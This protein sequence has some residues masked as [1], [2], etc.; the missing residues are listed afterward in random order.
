MT[1]RSNM[2]GPP[3]A[4]PAGRSG[5]GAAAGVAGRGQRRWR[6]S[7]EARGSTT[8]ATGAAASV[9]PSESAAAGVGR[10]T[11]ADAVTTGASDVSAR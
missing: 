1:R 11:A 9:R 10:S 7:A 8:G 4:R 3:V 5:A 2:G 6:V